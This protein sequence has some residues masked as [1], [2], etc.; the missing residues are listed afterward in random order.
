MDARQQAEARRALAGEL[1]HDA[2]A[3]VLAGIDITIRADQA[4]AAIAKILERRDAAKADSFAWE[5]SEIRH[6]AGKGIVAIGRA[7]FACDISDT[8]GK[9]VQFPDGKY[10]VRGVEYMFGSGEV[11]LIVTPLS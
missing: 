4:L 1:T 5:P 7:T 10:K 3:H 6:V 9:T 8:L 2:K 11:A